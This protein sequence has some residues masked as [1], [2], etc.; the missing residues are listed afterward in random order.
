MTINY[1]A[2][3]AELNDER[4]KIVHAMRMAKRVVRQKNALTKLFHDVAPRYMER[5]G[6]YTRILK[7]GTRHGDNAEMARIELV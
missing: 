7:M 2:A 3:R 6:G 5:Q 1:D 4:A